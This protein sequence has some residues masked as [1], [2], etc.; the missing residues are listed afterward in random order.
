M[1]LA[2]SFC[3][4]TVKC[5]G[6]CK[7]KQLELDAALERLETDNLDPERCKSVKTVTPILLIL[8]Q[9]TRTYFRNELGWKED[10]VNRTMSSF[11][12]DHEYYVGV[13][14]KVSEFTQDVIASAP[15]VSSSV[16]LCL[17][18]TLRW[19]AWT[20]IVHVGSWS[21]LRLLFRP[22]LDTHFDSRSP[23]RRSHTFSDNRTCGPCSDTSLY[24]LFLLKHLVLSQ[25]FCPLV[26]TFLDA[27]SDTRML[28]WTLSL[29]L[30]AQSQRLD[31]W[32]SLGQL[33][34]W[35]QP[36]ART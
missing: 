35:S 34:T 12:C 27:Y 30:N 23:L 26:D 21:P 2:Y 32:S 3:K 6:L 16:S 29:N 7:H 20:L 31:I 17:V 9:W 15:V 5:N 10:T 19:P 28:T 11:F 25:M 1:T 36:C 18:S 8:F 24:A 14:N 33:G 13:V 4:V 22:R